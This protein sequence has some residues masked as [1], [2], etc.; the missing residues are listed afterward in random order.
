MVQGK[1]VMALAASNAEVMQI[2]STRGACSKDLSD[3]VCIPLLRFCSFWHLHRTFGLSIHGA[4]AFVSEAVV[5]CQGSYSDSYR[6]LVS[7][8]A[9][10]LKLMQGQRVA[11]ADN[12]CSHH[13]MKAQKQVA[14]MV[15]P[16]T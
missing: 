15:L 14:H 6:L 3:E 7:T 5:F 4:H 12:V 10:S 13:S 16:K 9:F 2:L 8:C 11:L 1:T